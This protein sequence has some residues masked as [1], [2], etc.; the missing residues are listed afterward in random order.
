MQ[1]FHDEIQN[2]LNHANLNRNL[3]RDPNLNYNTLH[4]I[5]QQAKHMP[6]KMVKF[7][8]HKHKISPWIAR[9]ILQSIHYRDN[10]YKNHKMTDPNLPEFDVQNIILKTYNNIL[11]KAIRLAK[12]IH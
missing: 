8:K 12:P 11:K 3:N 1:N 4:V 5:I 2:A 9:G 6:M 7:D 10:L